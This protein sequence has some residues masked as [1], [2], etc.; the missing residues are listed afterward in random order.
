LAEQTGDLVDQSSEPTS[1]HASELPKEKESE[2]GREK[3]ADVELIVVSDVD[4][5]SGLG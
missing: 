3:E 5:E 1:V 4:A 2:D